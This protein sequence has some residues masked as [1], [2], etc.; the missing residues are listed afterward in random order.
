[1]GQPRKLKQPTR[2]RRKDLETTSQIRTALHTTFQSLRRGSNLDDIRG[3]DEKLRQIEGEADKAILKIYRD[4][5]NGPHDRAN[6]V[7]LTDLQD[8][9]GKGIDRCRE[10]GNL[11]AQI[12][13]KTSDV[14]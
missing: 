5:F 7:M 11:V 6:L 12:A 14:P 2:S 8:L 3:L 9:L 4:I 10:T 13:L 1:M